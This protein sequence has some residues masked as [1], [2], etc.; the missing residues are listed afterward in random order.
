MAQSADSYTLLLVDDN[1]TN[2]LLLVKIIELDLP[3]VRVLTAR[4]AREGL[5]LAA[6]ERIDGAFIDVQMPKMS[7]LEVC[8]RLNKKPRTA[9]IPMVLMTAHLAS[10][11]LRAEGLEAGAYDFITQPISNVEML[12]RIKVMLRLCDNE[13]R[14]RQGDGAWQQQSENRSLKFRWIAGLMISGDDIAAV[15]DRQQVQRLVDAFPEPTVENEERLY[16]CLTSDFPRPWRNTLLKLSLLDEVPLE[17]ARK[18]SEIENV[19]AAF[20]YLHRHDLAR[21]RSSSGEDRLSYSDGVRALLR[22]KAERQLD[23]ETRRQVRLVAVDSF[24]HSCDFVAALTCLLQAGEYDAASQLLSQFGLALFDRT[25]SN[26]LMAAVAGIPDD[27][28]ARCGWMSLFRGLGELRGLASEAAVWLELAYQVFEEADD[29]RGLLLALLYQVY[30]TVYVDGRY[31]RWIKR[32]PLMKSLV[33]TLLDVLEAEE[34]VR[35][36]AGY[37]QSKMFFEGALDQ[38]EDILETALSEAQREQLPLP[39]LDLHLM[40]FRLELH[41]GRLL[42]AKAAVEQGFK[43]AAQGV[44][45][46]RHSA[47]QLI[48]CEMLHAEGD[49]E[50]FRQQRSYLDGQHGLAHERKLFFPLLN[51]Y[52]A[53]L[54]LAFGDVEA[55]LGLLEIARMDSSVAVDTSLQSRLLQ[56]RG[57]CQ[58]L[59]GQGEKAEQDMADALQLR[60][61]TGGIFPRQENLLLAGMTCVQLGDYPRALEFFEK[62]LDESRKTGECRCRTGFFAWLALTYRALERPDDADRCLSEAVGLVKQHRNVFFWGLTAELIGALAPWVCAADRPELETLFERYLSAAVEA[63]EQGEPL[64]LL[65]VYSLGGFSLEA[66]GRSVDLSQVGHAS[67][68]IFALLM[69]S[70]KKS[71]SF[72]MLMGLLWPDS[73]ANRARNSFDAAHSRLRKALEEAFGKQVKKRYLVL[74]KGMLSLRNI[75]IDSVELE[76]LISQARHALQRGYDWQAETALLKAGSLWKGE[77][78]AGFELVDEVGRQRNELNRKRFEQLEMLAELLCKSDRRDA[79]IAFLRQGLLIDPTRESMVRQLLAL[80]RDRQ[81]N[82]EAAKLIDQYRAALKKADYGVSEVDELIDALGAHWLAPALRGRRS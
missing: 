58:A 10:P 9:G 33:E 45:G 35:V 14:L 28:A 51:Y 27:V 39:Q 47:L 20:D 1:P 40:Q 49:L 53:T 7:G 48:A 6:R 32:L 31:D 67:R 70:P 59:K 66:N 25:D 78:L 18:L 11:E 77:F 41:R 2:L 17:L 75:W 71:M 69:I 79:A 15:Q 62:G 61:R 82:R 19:K 60:E 24:R 80:Y 23:G 68:Q 56:L 5:E 8:R 3:G 36:L 50:G 13:R 12:A 29:S 65:R 52:E 44:E 38:V 72:E 73:P 63:H 54:T 37:G 42:V 46:I 34:R 16:D 26:A 55:A 57:F 43:I 30:L 21:I 4:S 74:E 64:P 76:G 81:D 22:D